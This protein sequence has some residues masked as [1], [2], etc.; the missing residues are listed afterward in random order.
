MACPL[1][2]GGLASLTP[3]P[4]TQ[5]PCRE[6]SRETTH[7]RAKLDVEG[8][9]ALAE[10]ADLLLTVAERYTEGRAGALLDDL[11][12]IEPARDRGPL[13][14]L[15]FVALTVLGRSASRHSALQIRPKP[16]LSAVSD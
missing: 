15:V 1:H 6:G 14:V 5:G 10:L 16:L 8:E 13:R 2:T 11:E 7:R 4:D 3:S 9:A 12:S